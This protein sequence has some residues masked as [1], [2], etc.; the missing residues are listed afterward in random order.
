MFTVYSL[1]YGDYPKLASKLLAGF[2]RHSQV[3]EYVFGLNQ[4]SDATRQVLHDWIAVS[5]SATIV[6]VEDCEKKNRGKYPLMRKMFEVSATSPS[7]MWFDDDSCVDFVHTDRWWDEIDSQWHSRSPDVVQCGAIHKIR[8]RG[9][10]YEV[11]ARQPWYTGQPLSA[12]SNYTFVT[13]G[14]WIADRSFLSQW[15]YPFPAI[16]HNGGDS[17]LGELVRQQGKKLMSVGRLGRC[18]C[19]SCSRKRTRMPVGTCVH[20]NVGGRTGRRGIGVRDERYVWAN[21]NV[22]PSLEHQDFTVEVRNY[23]F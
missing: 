18:H 7:V 13:G 21:G 4:I 9:L 22:D 14:W 17:I 3:T 11:V 6:T 16:H 15:D 1:L 2:C 5:Q 12:V 23:G 8:Q 20:I 19:E 10:Q